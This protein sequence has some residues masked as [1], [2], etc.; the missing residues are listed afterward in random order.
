MPIDLSRTGIDPGATA[1]RP[2]LDDLQGNILKGHGRNWSILIPIRLKRDNPAAARGWIADFARRFV[3]TA[4][5][6]GEQAARFRASNL[7]ALGGLFASFFLTARGYRTLGFPDSRIP[8]D[9]DAFFNGGGM[10]ARQGALRDPKVET[11]QAEF[12]QAIDAM[13]LLASDDPSDVRRQ[14]DVVQAQ[15][16]GIADATWTETGCR[17]LNRSQADVEPFGYVHNVSQP[18]FFKDDITKAAAGGTTRWD[19]SAPLD[20]VLFKDP[21]GIGDNSYGSFLVYRKL[22]QDVPRFDHTI[23]A[24]ARTLGISPA[25]AGAYAVGR[26]KD[27]TPVVLRDQPAGGS[28]PENDFDHGN[29]QMGSRCP[30]HA[31]TRKAN[32][33][34]DTHML[35]TPGV[36]WGEER[37]HRIV[38]RSV[39]FGRPEEI[40]KAPVGMHFLCFQA[41][42][43]LQFEFIQTAWSNTVGFLKPRTG[44]DPISGQR[45]NLPEGQ[46]WPNRWGD[47]GA[48]TT[49]VSL[50]DFVTLKGGDYFFA[51]SVGF[52]RNLDGRA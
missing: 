45:N 43:G 33:R 37:S 15:L 52:L 50:S 27:G 10:K 25:L 34:G 29:D 16:A 2:L 5:A 22:E 20:L 24:L 4:T 21:N 47:P 6:Q 39:T 13:A 31:H 32:P 1:S 18:L 8:R 19:P 23:S 3:T 11:W 42:L 49:R 30:F 7:P 26:F 51:P 12:Q 17:W 35:L 40:G 41:D 48:G 36:S 28:A 9:L 14:A 44:S 46:A 38:R